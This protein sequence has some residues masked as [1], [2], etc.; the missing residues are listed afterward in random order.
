MIDDARRPSHGPN[1]AYPRCVPSRLFETI[2][3]TRVRTTNNPMH[4]ANVSIVVVAG[5]LNYYCIKISVQ[6]NRKAT[7]RPTRISRE[8]VAKGLDLSVGCTTG[9]LYVMYKR[10]VGQLQHAV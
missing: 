5:G 4:T 8:T 1:V 2:R 3:R 10:N 9:A 7:K 6:T